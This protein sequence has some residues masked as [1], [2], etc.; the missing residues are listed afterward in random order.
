MENVNEILEEAK[1]KLIEEITVAILAEIDNDYDFEE[2][3]KERLDDVMYERTYE[4]ADSTLPVYDSDIVKI[5]GADIYRVSEAFER[6]KSEMGAESLNLE[7][8]TLIGILSTGLYHL[9]EQTLLDE[10][11]TI[12]E[13][14]G[15][16][17]LSE[18]KERYDEEK[19][20]NPDYILELIADTGNAWPFAIAGDNVK[21]NPIVLLE[22]VNIADW[23]CEHASERLK[24]LCAN[25]D[26]VSAL[27]SEILKTEL[28]SNL[29]KD[30][31]KKTKNKI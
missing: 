30:N 13:T 22:A 18:L 8:K 21:D 24:E 15:N 29:K 6:A 27:E 3:I 14:A 12:Y 31:S 1:S 23:I 26:P 16:N 19:L 11:Q 25:N 10:Q 5:V 17:A 20:D 28:D 2:I 7:N 4:I 9:I